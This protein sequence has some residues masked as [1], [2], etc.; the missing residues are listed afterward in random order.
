MAPIRHSQNYPDNEQPHSSSSEDSLSA[1]SSDKENYN[2][3]RRKVAKRKSDYAM[4]SAANNPASNASASNSKR[5]RLADLQTNAESTQSSQYQPRT[6]Q[7]PVT[8]YYDPDQDVGERREIRKSLR[9][10]TRDLNDYRNEYLQAG[11]KGIINTIQKANELFT[12]VKQTSD[13]TVDSQLLVN[14]ADLSYKKSAQLALGGAT[15]GIDVDEFVSKC[16]S[17]MSRGPV[18]DSSTIPSSTQRRAQNRNNGNESDGDDVDD[19]LNWDWLGRAACFPHNARPSLSGFLLGP[20]SIEKRTRQLTQHRAAN[21]IDTSRVIQ[22]QDLREEDLDTQETSNL[23]A[24]CSSINKLLRDKQEESM[25]AVNNELSTS[26]EDPPQE[27]I[28][29]VMDK[30]S[31]ADDGGIPLFRF[32]INPRSF[33]QSVENLFYISFLIRDG[34][35]G[36]SQDSRGLPTLQSARPYPPSEAQ[37]RGIEK[38][39]IIFSLDFE[40]W[41]DLIDSFNIKESIIPH[42]DDEVYQRQNQHGSGFG[43]GGGNGFLEKAIKEHVVELLLTR[44]LESEDKDGNGETALSL[45]AR[46][47]HQVIA[48]MRQRASP[49]L[50]SFSHAKANTTEA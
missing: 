47:G 8:D 14:A 34:N 4:S 35:I 12:R 23:T 43:H 45:A 49:G 37:G 7:R 29:R 19:T 18:N 17:F 9:D 38:H 16:M 40:L 2:H 44:G 48:D 1:T 46:N 32:C 27:E 13:A 20:L 30:H 10:L 15:T 50:R 5:R 33:G 3:G 22:P 42:R 39:Q 21:R 28:Q 6:S 25:A 36:V 11:N 41:Q 31:I 24:M 26:A